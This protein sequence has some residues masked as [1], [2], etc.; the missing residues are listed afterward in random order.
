[1][2]WERLLMTEFQKAD[3]DGNGTLDPH[4]FNSYQAKLDLERMKL[5]IEDADAQ[6]DQ[7]RKMAWFSLVGMLLYPF[8]VVLAS[9]LGL[10]QAADILGAMASIY[11]VSVAGIVGVFFGVTNMGKSSAK[12]DK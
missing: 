10:S 7:Q 3:T 11:F 9:W 8:S 12:T 6:R 5:E 2:P 1:M 4:E